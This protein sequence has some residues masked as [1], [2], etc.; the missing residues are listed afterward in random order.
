MSSLRG[1]NA[2]TSYRLEAQS[3]GSQPYRYLLWR[4]YYTSYI[5]NNKVLRV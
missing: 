1:E 3:G 5:K 4:L 2:A